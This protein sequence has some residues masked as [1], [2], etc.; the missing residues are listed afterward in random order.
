MVLLKP[1]HSFYFPLAAELRKLG[2]IWYPKTTVGPLFF[3]MC[4]IYADASVAVQA[5]QL[6]GGSWFRESRRDKRGC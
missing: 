2:G 5:P 1:L 3:S 6:L 4:L